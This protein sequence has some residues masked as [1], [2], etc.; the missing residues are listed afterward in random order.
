MTTQQENQIKEMIKKNEGLRLN[1]YICPTGHPTIGYGHLILPN[2][3]YTKITKEE[4]DKIF[5]SDYVKHKAGA[6]NFP[7]FDTLDWVRQGVIID[8]TFNLGISFFYKWPKFSAQMKSHDFESAAKNLLSTK[9]ASQVK[10]RAIR[11]ADMIRTGK[12]VIQ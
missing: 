8:M 9:Y 2:E 3:K 4:A 7:G 11:N 12:I 5:D 1:R 6:V 10:N